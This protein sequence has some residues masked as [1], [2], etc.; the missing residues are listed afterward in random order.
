MPC[1]D[2][3]LDISPRSFRVSQCCFLRGNKPPGMLEDDSF[4][5]PRCVDGGK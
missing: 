4:E 3:G 5:V 1:P 2:F